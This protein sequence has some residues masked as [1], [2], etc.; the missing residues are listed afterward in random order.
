MSDL[1]RLTKAFQTTDDEGKRFI[2]ALALRQAEK[3]PAKPRQQL[4]L[5][6]SSFGKSA[7]GDSDRLSG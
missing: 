2:L 6:T 7:V 4:R 1:E 3:Y 5:V